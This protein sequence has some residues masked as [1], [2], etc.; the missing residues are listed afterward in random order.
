M[1]NRNQF[2][3]ELKNPHLNSFRVVVSSIISLSSRVLNRL[4]SFPTTPLHLLNR[5]LFAILPRH[6][7]VNHLL[8]RIYNLSEPTLNL[9][10]SSGRSKCNF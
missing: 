8:I 3:A 2:G 4:I 9:L 6:L 10:H 1:H 5:I 7:S